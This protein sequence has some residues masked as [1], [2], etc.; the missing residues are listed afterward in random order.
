MSR[1]RA[2]QR[3]N[4][5]LRELAARTVARTADPDGKNR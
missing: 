3:E 2:S 1:I 4:I 5:K